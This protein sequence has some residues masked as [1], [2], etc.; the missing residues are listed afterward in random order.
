MNS[1]GPS[2]AFFEHDRE[3]QDFPSRCYEIPVSR[4]SAPEGLEVSSQSPPDASI[5]FS[6]SNLKKTI[7]R[8]FPHARPRPPATPSAR[9][10]HAHRLLVSRPPGRPRSPPPFIQ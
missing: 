6:T 4:A 8:Q 5:C 1:I 2:S 9:L 7:N 10:A 3:G